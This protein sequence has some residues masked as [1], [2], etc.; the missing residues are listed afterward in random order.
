MDCRGCHFLE[1]DNYVTSAYVFWQWLYT[2]VAVVFIKLSVLSNNLCRTVPSQV[3]CCMIEQA[4]Q[5]PLLYDIF[6]IIQFHI[7]LYIPKC[8][9]VIISHQQRFEGSSLPWQLSWDRAPVFSE[10]PSGGDTSRMSISRLRTTTWNSKLSWPKSRDWGD[11]KMSYNTCAL[12]VYSFKNG[13]VI[14]VN[15]YRIFTRNALNML[16]TRSP[17]VFVRVQHIYNCYNSETRMLIR[18]KSNTFLNTVRVR[19]RVN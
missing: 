13:C 11:P 12:C 15:V 8:P 10:C 14:F 5:L 19:V 2:K 9:C 4:R 7:I 6:P 3:S 16:G 17:N 1:N 18:H